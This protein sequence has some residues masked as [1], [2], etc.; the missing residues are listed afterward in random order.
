MAWQD[1]RTA[2]AFPENVAL[3][4]GLCPFGKPVPAMLRNIKSIV[5]RNT[6][7]DVRLSSQCKGEFSERRSKARISILF[8][9]SMGTGVV[10]LDERLRIADCRFLLVNCGLWIVDCGFGDGEVPGD[11]AGICRAARLEHRHDDIWPTMMERDPLRLPNGADF[12]GCAK[13]NSRP[14]RSTAYRS[15]TNERCEM[16]DA[17]SEST[18]ERLRN[19]QQ[20]VRSPSHARPCRV[21]PSSNGVPPYGGSAHMG[22][23]PL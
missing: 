18:S 14:A 16:P 17:R 3:S 8:E 1:A 10:E 11:W 2:S 12:G 23:S 15:H 22:P 7:H 5:L 19:G 9:R 13:N 20:A 21:G 6:S 4:R